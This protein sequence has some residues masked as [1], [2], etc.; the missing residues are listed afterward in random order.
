MTRNDSHGPRESSP[1]QPGSGESKV[2]SWI[3]IAVV[4][5]I[6]G[7]GWWQSRQEQQE[8]PVSV[9]ANR[10]VVGAAAQ[11]PQEDPAAIPE[12]VASDS[13]EPIE[14]TVAAESHADSVSDNSATRRLKNQHQSPRRDGPPHPG[15]ADSSKTQ[16]PRRNSNETIRPSNALKLE[17]QVIKDI[18]GRVVYRGEIDLTPTMDRITHGEKNSHRN[19]GTSFQNRERRLPAKPQGYYKEY[20]HPTQGISGPGPQRV[21]VGKDG[22]VWYTPDHYRT[23]DRIR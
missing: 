6:L 12:T 18:D 13:H 16:N 7:F 21:I 20:V 23:F 22:D 11:G 2:P 19:D 14:P 5:G 8:N 1:S 17:N 9:A 4:I 10:Q 15:I 3:V